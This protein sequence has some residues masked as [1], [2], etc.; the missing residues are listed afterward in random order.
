MQEYVQHIHHRDVYI[1]I[2]TYYFV[3][4]HTLEHINIAFDLWLFKHKR[5]GTLYVRM[6]HVYAY[7][8]I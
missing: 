5:T 6:H 4:N 8:N 2:Y 3:T 1:Y 7:N